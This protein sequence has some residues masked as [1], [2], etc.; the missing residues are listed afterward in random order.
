MREPINLRKSKPIVRRSGAVS[1]IR[2][3]D[4]VPMALAVAGESDNH[5]L[6]G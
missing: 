6:L 2:K 3:F 5:H 1:A 4:C